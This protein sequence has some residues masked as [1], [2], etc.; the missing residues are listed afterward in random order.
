MQTWPDGTVVCTR[1]VYLMLFRSWNGVSRRVAPWLRVQRV[2]LSILRIESKGYTPLRSPAGNLCFLPWD[3]RST[4][5]LTELV[6]ENSWGN[7]RRFCL[8]AQRTQVVFPSAHPPVPPAL[9]S[10]ALGSPLSLIS[11]SWRSCG[12]AA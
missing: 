12:C 9:S 8:R 3:S 6:L 2:S 5:C 4:L 1:F 10:W 11:V 7:Y